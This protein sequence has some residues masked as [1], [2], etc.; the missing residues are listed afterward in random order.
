MES[1]H[2]WV[3][4]PDQFWKPYLV[5]NENLKTGELS[6]SC[7]KG[8][9]NV[10]VS[11]AATLDVSEED[12]EDLE[13]L[14]S[15]DSIV[16]APILDLVRRRYS[17]S[18]HF[19]YADDVLLFVNPCRPLV[20]LDPKS[21]F[22]FEDESS[23]EPHIYSFAN[24]VYQSMCEEHGDEDEK[25]AC[26][27]KKAANKS[28]IIMGRVGAGK[29]EMEKMVINFLASANEIVKKGI[30]YEMP[31][32]SSV[33][34]AGRITLES[35]GSAANSQNPNSSRFSRHTKLFYANNNCIVSA[36]TTVFNIEF[37]RVVKLNDKDRN[38]HIFYEMVR[39]LQATNHKLANK[40]KVLRVEDF[41]I[42]VEGNG[43]VIETE[44][45]DLNGFLKLTESLAVVGLSA[46]EIDGVWG[47]LATILH[48]GNIVYK[49]GSVSDPLVGESL[50]V[51]AIVSM[52]GIEKENFVQVMTAQMMTVGNKRTIPCGNIS[53]EN[54]KNNV[55]SVMKYLYRKLFSWMVRKINYAQGTVGQSCGEQSEKYIGV[56]DTA[57]FEALASNN[58]LQQLSMNYTCEVFQQ[59]FLQQKFL[60]EQEVYADE[61]IDWT[62][63][64]FRDNN[65]VIDLL[66][67]KSNGLFSILEEHSMMNRKPDDKAFLSALNSTL[68]GS[69]DYSKPRFGTEYF[70]I[71]HYQEDVVYTTTAFLLNNNENLHSDMAGYLSAS[72]NSLIHALCNVE[73]VQPGEVGYVPSMTDVLVESVLKVKDDAMLIRRKVTGLE[74]SVDKPKKLGEPKGVANFMHKMSPTSGLVLASVSF[75]EILNEVLSTI[76]AT[77]QKFVM[78]F[79]PNDALKPGAFNALHFL[80][81]YRG[82][83]ISESLSMYRLKYELKIPFLDFI[84]MYGCLQTGGGSWQSVLD[85]SD[86]Y[87]A[88]MLTSNISQSVLHTD[89]YRIGS[90]FNF[91]HLSR[92]TILNKP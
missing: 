48:M 65:G 90:N 50:D 75:K 47:L 41:A 35:F 21:F 46:S 31:D 77:E 87:A 25:F 33:L 30:E 60:L 28:I 76:K 18:K 32:V 44:Q 14:N 56:L 58:S 88:K 84:S 61:G 19:T 34:M 89:S 22:S 9:T 3:A 54:S 29:S 79:R 37:S 59:Q 27:P 73:A 63:V 2:V 10:I 45:K 7:D 8:R 1:R 11:K 67:K 85:S 57:G 36:A 66:S 13:D 26:L 16:E 83:R 55:Q 91:C 24:A 38:F 20:D 52:L 39:G 40:L 42:L 80:S 72:T 49:S 51:D 17:S 5:T 68:E 23:S 70:I 12:L 4:D 62:P 43:T 78:C 92:L 6:I 82:T 15:L 86:T 69:L 81:Q 71:K 74:F 53:A 64:P